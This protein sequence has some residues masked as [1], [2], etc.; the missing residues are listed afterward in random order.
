[1]KLVKDKKKGEQKKIIILEEKV[2]RLVLPILM[3][4][5]QKTIKDN[6][7]IKFFCK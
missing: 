4:L 1:M 2:I 7:C 6:L 3:V 5:N